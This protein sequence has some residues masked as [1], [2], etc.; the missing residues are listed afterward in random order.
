[1]VVTFRKYVRRDINL[2]LLKEFFFELCQFP[3]NWITNFR[4]TS[5][6][7]SSTYKEQINLAQSSI[8]ETN[9]KWWLGIK[10]K[11]KLSF[12]WEQY[13]DVNIYNWRSCFHST[14]TYVT[15]LPFEIKV[16][17]FK[18]RLCLFFFSSS[19]VFVSILI[20]WLWEEYEVIIQSF[21]FAS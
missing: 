17:L 21:V 6:L 20:Y 11:V 14:K 19:S 3:V 7:I 8:G 18:A 5:A 15:K 10:H 12:C 13:F 1:M 9:I 16:T 2:L 4:L